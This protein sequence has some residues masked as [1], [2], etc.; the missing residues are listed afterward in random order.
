M[1]RNGKVSIWLGNIEDQESLEKYVNLTYDD[2]GESVSSRFFLDFNID[3]DDTDEDFIEK[4]V[5]ENKSK[6]LPVLLEGCSYE[7]TVIPKVIKNISIEKYYNSII[8]IY[9]FDYEESV[10]TVSNF[11]Y[12][13]SVNY[14]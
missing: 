8:L 3:M 13:T 5:L 9:N 2:D 1:E 12:I 11:D 4:A 7:D 10:K 14:L 6:D